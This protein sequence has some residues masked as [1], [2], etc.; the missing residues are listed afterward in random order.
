MGWCGCAG[1]AGVAFGVICTFLLAVILPTFLPYLGGQG[2]IFAE[3]WLL[4]VRTSI[5]GT[6]NNV[7]FLASRIQTRDKYV[8]VRYFYSDI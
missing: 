8:A 7:F 6:N 1:T 4:L 3:L 2:F 5:S